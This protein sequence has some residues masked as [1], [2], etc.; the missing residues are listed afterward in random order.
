MGTQQLIHAITQ[1]QFRRRIPQDV[2]VHIPVCFKLSRRGCMSIA[3]PK[4][5]DLAAL[6]LFKYLKRSTFGGVRSYRKLTPS[7]T[8]YDSELKLLMVKNK[9]IGVYFL[10]GSCH[11]VQV[12]STP[13]IHFRSSLIKT[14]KASRKEHADPPTWAVCF[15]LSWD[16]VEMSCGGGDAAAS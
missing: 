1:L 12:C 14:T 10:L 5:R 4:L 9:V 3:T 16:S 7:L 6:S 13:I 8:S 2:Y 15:P 11:F